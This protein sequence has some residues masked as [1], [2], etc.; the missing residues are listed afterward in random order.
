MVCLNLPYIYMHDSKK[1]SAYNI[2]SFTTYVK[3]Y[4][5]E[6]SNLKIKKNHFPN[7]RC[8]N[9]AANSQSAFLK[10]YGFLII[11]L[12]D[13]Y[14]SWDATGINTLNL[15]NP[16]INAI[17]T[18]KP[19]KNREK[20]VSDNSKNIENV[21]RNI[22]KKQT[23]SWKS[24]NSPYCRTKLHIGNTHLKKKKKEISNVAANNA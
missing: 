5:Q 24:S 10:I 3:K 11:P 15:I 22:F 19:L 13:I 20:G 18:K 9:L 12:V 17:I 8:W 21:H 2:G 14:V 16:K 7:T 4:R 23:V 1:K 6:I